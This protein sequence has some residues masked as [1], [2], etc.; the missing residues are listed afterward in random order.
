M[1][2]LYVQSDFCINDVA[3]MWFDCMYVGTYCLRTSK[4]FPLILTYVLGLYVRM[5]LLHPSAIS[6]TTSYVQWTAITLTHSVGLLVC[7]HKYIH[8]Y[9][10]YVCMCINMH[11]YVHNNMYSD[12][13]WINN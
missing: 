13:N 4:T 9:T 1:A 7:E 5:Y 11:K 3:P 6:M 10:I 2:R 12:H 8:T